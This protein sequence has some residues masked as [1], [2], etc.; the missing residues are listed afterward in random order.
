MDFLQKELSFSFYAWAF[1]FKRHFLERYNFH[2]AEGLIFEDLQLIPR[3]LRK[4]ECVKALPFM[5]YNY[6]QR[7][8]S[9]V[10]TV[11]EK[12]LIAFVK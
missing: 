3:I 2:F 6:R 1:V 12:C 4:A 9:I 8:G 11:N 5:A 10:N 7:K